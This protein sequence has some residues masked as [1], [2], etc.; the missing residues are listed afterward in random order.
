TTSPLL[1][2][3]FSFLAI[4]FMLVVAVV[5]LIACNNIAILLLAKWFARRREIG[6]RLALGATRRQLIRQLIAENLALSVGGGV[7]AA[8][9]AVWTARVLAGFAFPVP[10][11]HGLAFELD[12]RVAAFAAGLALSTAVLFGL[13]PSLQLVKTDV[14]A[15]LK[16]T[17][18]TGGSNA[19]RM[20]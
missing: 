20:R 8:I 12:W 9:G 4:L 15:S 11:P 17:G 19:I 7:C 13:G 10:M 3:Q 18:L 6:I 16:E 1:A 2:G 14:L 5:L